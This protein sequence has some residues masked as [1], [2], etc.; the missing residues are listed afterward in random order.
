MQ[1]M[2]DIRPFYVENNGE[3]DKTDIVCFFTVLYF[4]KFDILKKDDYCIS[5]KDS[6]S[7]EQKCLKDSSELSAP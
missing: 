2:L 5:K 3:M 1:L 6:A 7:E 4:L